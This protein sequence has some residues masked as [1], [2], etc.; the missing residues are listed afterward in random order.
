MKLQET[1]KGQICRLNKDLEN[2]DRRAREMKA[3][4]TKQLAAMDAE[5]HQ[6]IANLR[7]HNED[8]IMRLTDEKE[9][10]KYFL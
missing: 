3:S 7:K 6:T 10:V 8:C 5:Y 2:S 4:L 1:L 9:Q